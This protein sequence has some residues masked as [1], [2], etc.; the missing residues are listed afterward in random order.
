MLAECETFLM[1]SSPRSLA[2]SAEYALKMPN[3]D[4][5]LAGGLEWECPPVIVFIDDVSGNS[6]KQWNVH[7]SCYMSNGGLPR[8]EVD[9]SVN[10]HFVATSP[11]AAPME[12]MSAICDELR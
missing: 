11:H 2:G 10:V 12:I 9:K 4:R 8:S 7:Y 5:V 1:M 6:T 3:P